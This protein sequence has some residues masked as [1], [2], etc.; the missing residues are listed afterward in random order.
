[1]TPLKR[2]TVLL[3]LLALLLTGCGG[4]DPTPTPDGD[5]GAADVGGS[6]NNG[7]TGDGG[8]AGGDVTGDGSLPDDPPLITEDPYVGVDTQAFYENYTP[9]VSSSDATWRSKHHLMSGDLTVP[10]Q[11]PTVATYQPT[12]NG[13]LVRNDSACYSS[14]GTTYYIL[15]GYGKVVGAVHFGGA[16]ITLEEVAAYLMAFGELPAN[17]THKKVTKVNGN[18]WGIYLRGNHSKF[19]GNTSKY[20]YEPVL[21]RINGCGGDLQYYELDIGTTG[22]DCDPGYSVRIYNDGTRITRGAARIVYTRFDKNGDKIIDVSEKYL[23][24][25]YNHYN[26]FREYLNYMG[27]WGTMFGNVTGGGTL[28]SKTNCNPTPYVEVAR[29]EF[30]VAPDTAMLAEACV[31][32]VVLITIKA[33]QSA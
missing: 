24:Y 2:L 11:A 9:A 7:N 16:Y 3:L 28:S 10:D 31:A 26:D 22:T 14:D 30:Y 23:F 15:D 5:G 13:M 1:M 12:R 19:S 4:V 21:P 8:N 18:A 17:Y 20:P 25:T 32:E 33:L 6:G 27:G 29:A